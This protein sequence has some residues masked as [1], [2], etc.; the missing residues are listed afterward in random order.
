M[1]SSDPTTDQNAILTAKVATMTPEQRWARL[2]ELADGG[3]L[4]PATR[5]EFVKL[6]CGPVAVIIDDEMP[7]EGSELS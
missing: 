6:L 7:A 3:D 1:P 4:T 2:Q 5:L